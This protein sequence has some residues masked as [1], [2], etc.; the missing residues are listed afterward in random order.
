MSVK[1]SSEGSERLKERRRLKRRRMRILG[2]VFIVAFAGAFIWFTW[3]PY[4]RITQVTISNGDLRAEAAAREKLKGSYLGVVPRDSYFFVSEN[5]IRSAVITDNATYQAV[6]IKRTGFTSLA[7]VLHERVP[8]ARWCGLKP[9]TGDAFAISDGE[10]CYLFD[11]EGYIYAASDVATGTPTLNAFAVYDT[12]QGAT[13]EPL[14]ATLTHASAIP[15]A[16]D[17]A[18]KVATLGSAV[19][20][21]VFHGDEVSIYLMSGTRLTY[22]LG[23]EEGA[24]T[25]LTS[26]KQKLNFADGSLEYVDL[27]FS[28][29]VYLKRKGDSVAG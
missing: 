28:G 23:S 5:A 25:D 9:L 4:V 11:A 29:K 13:E 27:R 1:R 14:H 21:V 16:F 2:G 7:L 22:V 3:Q 12:L 18:R 26:A 24:F 6:S 19:N 8:V 20:S 10:Y 15:N 17:F